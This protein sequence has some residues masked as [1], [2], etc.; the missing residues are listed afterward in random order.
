VAPLPLSRPAAAPPLRPT[1][2]LY[3]YCPVYG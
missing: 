3:E 2:P 1:A